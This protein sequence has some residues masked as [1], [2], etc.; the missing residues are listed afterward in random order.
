[1]KLPPLGTFRVFDMAAQTQSF[2]KAAERL[3]VTHGAVSRQ[4]RILEEA[5][6]TTLFERRNRAVF[7]TAA[8]RT[9]QVT[10]ASIFEQLE[11]AVQRLQQ[12]NRESA[13]VLSCE[14]TIAMKWLIPRL[15][16]FHEAH[17]DIAIHLSA[18]GGPIDLARAGVD[19][20][21]RRDDFKWA[22]DIHATPICE[23]WVG[24]V[25]RRGMQPF[26]N[27][28]AGVKLIHTKSRPNAWRTWQRLSRIQTKS[29]MRIDYEH[30]YLC[31]QA[32]VAGLGVA[33]VSRFMVLD[34][35]AGGQLEAPCG[36]LKDGSRYHLLSTQ[37]LVEDP[38]CALFASWLMEQMTQGIEQAGAGAE[39]N[40]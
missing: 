23:E 25:C 18:A 38:K 4:I 35:L 20:A 15:P 14:P 11:V 26:A 19:L 31:V 3:H 32:A 9:L 29:S 1:M 10:T 5:V 37:P 12:N 24:P 22:D 27:G 40:P 13:L 8:G 2:V 39:Q 6:G 36:F 30:F 21:L 34:E 7:L 33:M 16:A 17:P 28:M